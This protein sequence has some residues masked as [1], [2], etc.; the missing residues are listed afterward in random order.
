MIWSP[1]QDCKIREIF[2]SIKSLTPEFDETHYGA[3]GGAQG[4]LLNLCPLW[5]RDDGNNGDWVGAD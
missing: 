5:E 3:G 1:L 4:M 2:P